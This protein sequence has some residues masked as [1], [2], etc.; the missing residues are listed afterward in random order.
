[1][2]D[3]SYGGNGIFL[4]D[5]C[6]CMS[7]GITPAKT[8]DQLAGMSRYMACHHYKVAYNCTQ[9]APPD[10]TFLAG[11]SSAY[12]MLADHAEDIICNHP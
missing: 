3:S 2:I 8:H 10:I 6:K 7:P 9:P 12:C 11:R 5:I 4:A 1:M